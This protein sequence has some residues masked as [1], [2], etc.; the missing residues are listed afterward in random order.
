MHVEVCVWWILVLPIYNRRVVY[1]LLQSSL[2]LKVAVTPV[3]SVK[4]DTASSSLGGLIEISKDQQRKWAVMTGVK[5]YENEMDRAK[6]WDDGIWGRP[7]KKAKMRVSVKIEKVVRVKKM[8]LEKLW[9][10]YNNTAVIGRICYRKSRAKGNGSEIVWWCW[11]YRGAMTVHQCDNE[12]IG[13]SSKPYGTSS[14]SALTQHRLKVFYCNE[15][16]VWMW[17]CVWERF[18]S[19]LLSHQHVKF[20]AELQQAKNGNK[21]DE[22]KEE[23]NTDGNE[24]R[25]RKRRN[26]S[27]RMRSAERRPE[28]NIRAVCE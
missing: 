27:R 21:K 12:G 22:D 4:A 18:H 24:G 6:A 7:R 26:A 13:P 25:R 8:G 28:I 1:W 5:H 9:D 20:A 19:A 3:G 17:V 16:R 14:P 15:K 23:S 2:D 11:K 10:H